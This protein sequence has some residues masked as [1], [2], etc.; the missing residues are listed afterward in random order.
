MKEGNGRNWSNILLFPGLFSSKTCW[1]LRQQKTNKFYIYTLKSP[2]GIFALGMNCKYLPEVPVCVCTAKTFSNIHTFHH[3]QYVWQGPE[4]KACHNLMSSDI[5]W[6]NSCTSLFKFWWLGQNILFERSLLM[7]FFPLLLR[8]FIT[9]AAM[10]FAFLK[11]NFIIDCQPR[12]LLRT[13]LVVWS[14]PLAF[15]Y[16]RG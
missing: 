2:W 10:Y 4:C 9:N 7:Y 12:S 5:K 13:F 15:G 14:H 1:S 6:Q 16:G 11:N 8:Y 3:M